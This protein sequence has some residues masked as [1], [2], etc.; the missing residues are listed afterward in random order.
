[1][2]TKIWCENTLLGPI[3]SEQSLQAKM[4]HGSQSTV[5]WGGG[6]WGEKG[7]GKKSKK[8]H[9]VRKADHTQKLYQS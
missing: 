1:M 5:F 6:G 4:H 2:F 9:T 3:C 8:D 7:Q